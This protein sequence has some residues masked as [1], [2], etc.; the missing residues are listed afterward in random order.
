[1]KVQMRVCIVGGPCLYNFLGYGNLDSPVWFVGVE[2]GG[3][4]IWRNQTLSLEESLRLRPQYSLSMDF[5]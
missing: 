5:V 2:E 3:A 1:M 4:E